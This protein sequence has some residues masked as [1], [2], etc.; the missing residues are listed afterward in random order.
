MKAITLYQP[1][2]SLVACGAKTIETRSWHTWYTGPLAIHAA[3]TEAYLFLA[4]APGRFRTALLAAGVDADNL[5]TGAVIATSDLRACV[6]IVNQ[7]IIDG[8]ALTENEIHFGDWSLDRY[9][10]VL[11]ETRS[12]HEPI[13]AQG[14][15]RIWNWDATGEAQFAHSLAERTDPLADAEKRAALDKLEIKADFF[16]KEFPDESAT[17]NPAN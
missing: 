16:G 9:A 1:Y 4:Q 5:P 8:L 13:P 2:A 17:P 15:Q 3:Q 14:A 12:L 6:Q 10:W 7:S 11:D